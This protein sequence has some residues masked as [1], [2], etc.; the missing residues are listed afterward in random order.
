M[1]FNGLTID[2]FF[3][4]TGSFPALAYRQ[5]NGKFLQGGRS[6]TLIFYDAIIWMNKRAEREQ[7][8]QVEMQE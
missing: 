4:L 2:P 6:S 5:K 3:R 1:T 7:I 8:C